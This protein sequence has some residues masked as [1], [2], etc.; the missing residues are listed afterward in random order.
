MRNAVWPGEISGCSIPY[1]DVQQVMEEIL[2]LMDWLQVST[3][4]SQMRHFCARPEE[5]LHVLCHKL[6]R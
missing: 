4:A 2:A 6:L 5:A 1:D 3:V